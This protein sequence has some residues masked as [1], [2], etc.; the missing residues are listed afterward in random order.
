MVLEQ[1]S[2]E[3]DP[4]DRH[5]VPRHD[6]KRVSS[7]IHSTPLTQ[8]FG[9]F[10]LHGIIMQLEILLDRL[11][12]FILFSFYISKVHLSFSII[13]AV[14]SCEIEIWL[15]WGLALHGFIQF[16]FVLE[17]LIFLNILCM[18][19]LRVLSKDADFNDKDQHISFFFF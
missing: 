19:K 2:M 9:I 13:L 6:M 15:M 11:Q 1:N 8:F 5:D 4:V 12:T 7:F 10:F 16:V 14:E 3:V 17:L 18:G